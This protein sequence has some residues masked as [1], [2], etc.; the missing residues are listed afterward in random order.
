MTGKL[1]KNLVSNWETFIEFPWWIVLWG[2]GPTFGN[3][4]ISLLIKDPVQFF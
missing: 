1:T 4:S 3:L 2:R